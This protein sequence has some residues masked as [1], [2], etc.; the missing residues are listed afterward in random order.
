MAFGQIDPARLQGDALRRWYLRSPDE[1]EGERR[2]RSEQA[3]KQFYSGIHD[4]REPSDGSASVA[5]AADPFGKADSRSQAVAYDGRSSAPTRAVA[6]QGHKPKATVDDCAGCHGAWPHAPPPPGMLPPFGRLPIPGGFPM[7][8]DLPGGA[9]HPPRREDRKQC[10]MQENSDRGICSQ[11]PTE[12]AKAVC[13]SNIVERR[14]HCNETGEIGIPS[15]FR[16][17]RKSG[18]PWP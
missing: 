17:R 2:Q 14:E 11:Q 4:L 13:Y 9:P 16:A 12:A 7:F 5:R 8:R 6:V 18:R 1:T 3:H 15:L 10:E